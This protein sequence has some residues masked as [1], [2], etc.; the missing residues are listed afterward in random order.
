MLGVGN[1]WFHC[2]GLPGE[3][4]KETE[5]DSDLYSAAGGAVVDTETEGPSEL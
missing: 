2:S 5:T 1:V 3:A 4:A